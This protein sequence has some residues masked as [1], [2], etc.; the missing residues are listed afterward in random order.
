MYWNVFQTSLNIKGLNIFQTACPYYPVSIES[1]IFYC[2]QNL[3]VL[4]TRRYGLQNQVIL[5]T[6]CY[7]AQ[8][9]VVLSTRCYCAQNLVVLS[10]R[11]YIKMK[12]PT[13]LKT[14]GIKASLFENQYK[15]F[16]LGLQNSRRRGMRRGLQQSPNYPPVS[17]A[18]PPPATLLFSL[19]STATSNP[20]WIIVSS[21]LD[22]QSRGS[23]VHQPYK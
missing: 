1:T 19:V 14:Y 16:H 8:N 7:C 12:T 20:R 11:F 5:P 6:R 15:V 17:S 13:N 22:S 4:Y 10:T 9:L 3:V 23:C 18:N 2:P 21:C